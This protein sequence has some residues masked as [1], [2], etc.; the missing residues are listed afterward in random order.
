[1]KVSDHLSEIAET[2]L[3][4]VF[5]IC[6]RHLTARYGTPP[7]I[8]KQGP[9]EQ[10]FAVIAYG[11]LGGIE[12]GYGSDLDLVFLHAGNAAVSDSPGAIDDTTFF[13]R[14]GQRVLH[15]LTTHTP[16]GFLYE[17]DMRLRPS[18]SAGMLVSHI[19][20]FRQY[21]LNNAWTWEH[22]AIVRAR[23]I[24]GDPRLIEQFVKIRREVLT[25]ARKASRLK[26]EVGDMRERLRQERQDKTAASFDLKEA[27]GGLVDIEFL[28]QYLVLLNTARHP[29]LSA[30]TDNVRLIHALSSTGVLD[31]DSAGFLRLAYLTFRSTIHRLNLQQKPAHVPEDQFAD[32]RQ[33]VAEIWNRWIQNY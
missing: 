26:H 6:R 4:E 15:I 11:K 21:Q 3:A 2:V 10:G 17:A 32:L 29:E 22:Q 9:Y 7:C 16:A 25:R 18:G 28:V 1:M 14:L 27:P 33:G 23:A 5:Q 12:L 13:A 19:Q 20:G 8:A 30:W 24:S 31:E